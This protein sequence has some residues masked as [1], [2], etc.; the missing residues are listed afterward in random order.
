MVEPI[1]EHRELDSEWE[2]FLI[3]VL[4]ERGEEIHT[5]DSECT[6]SSLTIYINYL[7]SNMPVSCAF[8]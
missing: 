1:L 6:E 7:Q 3:T 8:L 5:H 2:C 4:L